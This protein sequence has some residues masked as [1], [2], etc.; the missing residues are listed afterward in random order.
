M[1]EIFGKM[2]AQ[3]D[4]KLKLLKNPK[5]NVYTPLYII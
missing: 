4:R 1:A 5:I 3:T 2:F